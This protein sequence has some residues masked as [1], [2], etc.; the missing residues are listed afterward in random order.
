MGEADIIKLVVEAFVAIVIILAFGSILSDVLGSAI[1][2]YRG[3]MYEGSFVA[4]ALI[5]GIPTTIIAIAIG[6]I[7]KCSE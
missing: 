6:M 2:T 5:T 1:E 3:T 4:L 7:K